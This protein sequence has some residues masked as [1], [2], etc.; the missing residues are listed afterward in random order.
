MKKTH[1]NFNNF[2]VVEQLWNSLGRFFKFPSMTD[3]FLI[4]LKAV[5]KTSTSEQ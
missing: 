1:T 2:F 4:I 3:F 5:S